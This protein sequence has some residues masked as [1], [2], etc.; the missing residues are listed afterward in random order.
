[1]QSFFETYERYRTADIDSRIIK[2]AQVKNLLSS[3]SSQFAVSPIG[4]SVE[5]RAIYGVRIGKGK[6]RILFWS[7]MHGDESTAT[8]ALFDVFNF[9]SASDE[10]DELRK[11]IF[12]KLELFFIPMLN[13]DGAERNQRENAYR[14]D[15]NRDARKF[16]TPE[17]QILRDQTKIF[18]PHFSFNL[19]DQESYYSA[20]VAP[21][22]AAISFLAPPPDM[23]ESI[24]E[25]RRNAMQ[26]IVLLNKQLQ[27]I[28]PNCVGKW[29]DTYEPRA[30]GEWSQAQQSA[31]I[32]VESGGYYN[33][34]ERNFVRKLN[35]ALLLESLRSIAFGD[36]AN[37]PIEPY[38]MIPYNRE[39]GMFDKL[40][41]Q[42]TITN[43]GIS[44]VTDV[45]HRKDEVVFGDLE[46]YGS[47]EGKK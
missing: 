10:Y 7:Q 43:K 21:Y 3:L 14:I 16:T 1:M 36:Y 37:E 31:T 27:T 2:H 25:N 9:L 18:K 29:Q 46:S 26:L 4:K 42:E 35:F 34:T 38:F 22:P 23:Q 11:Q 20:G 6:T 17:G 32:L 39:N 40:Q 33:D 5:E 19:H 30:F 8:R 45:G 41:R 47:L 12:E 13:P 24:T 44:Y 15:I 28:I